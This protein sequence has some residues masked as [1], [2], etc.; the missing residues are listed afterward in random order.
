VSRIIN[1]EATW[2]REFQNTY[3]S[4]AKKN[5]HDVPKMFGGEIDVSS[6]WRE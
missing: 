1:H 4:L 6:A 3:Y 5:I 2:F